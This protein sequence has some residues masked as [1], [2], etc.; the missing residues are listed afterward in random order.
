MEVVTYVGFKHCLTAETSGPCVKRELMSL[1]LA[2]EKNDTREAFTHLCLAFALSPD[3]GY[4]ARR[5]LSVTATVCITDFGSEV[6]DARG[7]VKL[8]L[9]VCSG[10]VQ[11]GSGRSGTGQRMRIGTGWR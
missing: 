6:T 7:L 2:E 1:V 4:V 8:A 3:R 10:T 9:S 11:Y 5:A